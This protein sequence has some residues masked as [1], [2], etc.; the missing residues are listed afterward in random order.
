MIKHKSF[1]FRLYPNK[2]QETLINKTFGCVRF[3]YNK[4]LELQ[5]KTYA[6]TKR[7][8]GRFECERLLPGIKAEFP[9]LKEVD[10]TALKSANSNLAA[11]YTA[12]FS[13]RSNAPIFHKKGRAESYTTTQSYI[14][15]E[16]DRVFLP[17]LGW[18]KFAKSREPKGRIKQAIISR[19][20]SGRYYISFICETEIP[21]LPTCSQVC[22]VDVGYRQLAT[23][24]DGTTFESPKPLHAALKKLVR[25]QRKLSRQC[26]GSANWEKQRVIIAR[27]HERIANIRK[28]ALHK[29]TTTLIRENQ[30]ICIEGLDVRE[31]MLNRHTA[32]LI[33]DVG[34]GEFR[35]MLE[36]KAKWHGRQVVAVPQ[37]YPSSQIC[38]ACGYRHEK[39]GSQEYW[40][41]PHC[42]TRH[43]RDKNAAINIRREGLAILAVCAA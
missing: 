14:R 42:G 3:V 12:F 18:T 22:G 24:D 33:C 16:G 6:E 15:V 13:G 40:A 38:S 5:E 9:F 41:C 11:A 17:K 26:K 37:S 19:H 28:D 36:Y 2:A 27:L 30:T 34:L 32:K 23:L 21:P 29:A 39:L 8:M 20:S 4:M 25:E 10:N 43:N 35:Q 1:R 7:H 31:M